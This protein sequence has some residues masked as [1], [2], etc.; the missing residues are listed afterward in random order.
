MKRQLLTY[1]DAKPAKGQH[2]KPC[3]DCSW[4]RASLKGWTGDV[5]PEGW[6]EDVHG[7]ARIECH[8]KLGAQ[9][10]GAA[11]Y[12]SNVLKS[13]RDKS[14]LILPANKLLVFARPQEFLDHHNEKKTLQQVPRK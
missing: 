11:I 5:P 2:K 10:A 9:C 6:I 14:L 13:P 4:A 8:T 1:L 3:S 7:E 12:R